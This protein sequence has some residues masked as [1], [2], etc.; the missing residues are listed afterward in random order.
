MTQDS[1]PSSSTPNIT[2]QDLETFGPQPPHTQV[3]DTRDLR[4]PQGV[5]EVLAYMRSYLPEGKT[6]S[7][8]ADELDKYHV[9]N[10]QAH[11]SA[12][13]Y[14]VPLYAQKMLKQAQ[15]GDIHAAVVLIQRAWSTEGVDPVILE[16]AEKAKDSVP[17]GP[18][19]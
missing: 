15:A 12:T 8:L 3:R 18:T 4:D 17:E 5:G 2:E 1:S 6:L 9:P 7:A 13:A 16:R 11:A 14:T 10:H 19:D